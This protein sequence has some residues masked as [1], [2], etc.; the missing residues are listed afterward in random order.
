MAQPGDLD[1]RRPLGE[2]A[3][4]RV[5]AGAGEVQQQVDPVAA[6]DADEVVGAGV[7]AVVPVRSGERGWGGGPGVRVDVQRDLRPVEGLEQRSHGWLQRGSGSFAPASEDAEA[8]FALAAVVAGT[9]FRLLAWGA[10]AMALLAGE[11]GQPVLQQRVVQQGDELARVE[12]HRQRPLRRRGRLGHAG[13]QAVEVGRQGLPVQI[14]CTAEGG[15]ERGIGGLWLRVEGHLVAPRGLGVFLQPRQALA[16]L[17]QGALVQG[18]IRACLGH[19][20]LGVAHRLPVVPQRGQGARPGQVPGGAALDA[21]IEQ[22]QAIEHLGRA[23]PGQQ[24]LGGAHAGGGVAPVQVEGLARQQQGRQRQPQRGGRTGRVV[25]WSCLGACMD[26]NFAMPCRRTLGPVRI[27][28]GPRRRTE[29]GSSRG[30]AEGVHDVAGRAA[31]GGNMDSQS[32]QRVPGASRDKARHGGGVRSSGSAMKKARA[33]ICTGF[34]EF[35][36]RFTDSNRGP[37]DY[38]SI[39]LTD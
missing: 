13:Q 20:C 37:V 30:R 34:S 2:H 22:V 33:A 35:W 18:R 15:G 32:R 23:V 9:R 36:W 26:R 27:D 21:G 5:V 1:R 7:A 16:E 28:A 8:P 39:A 19:R 12:R 14:R 24:Q 31:V 6:D 10:G 4:T 11:R 29:A 17:Q 38:D 3:Q 25:V